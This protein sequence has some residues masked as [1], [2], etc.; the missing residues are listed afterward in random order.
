MIFIICFI[1][2]FALQIE[3]PFICKNFKKMKSTFIIISILAF[4]KAFSQPTLNSSVLPDVGSTASNI[5]VEPNLINTTQTGANTTWNFINIPTNGVQSSAT[6]ISPAGQ[7]GALNFPTANLCLVTQTLINEDI[8]AVYLR[9]DNNGVG[10]VGQ[11]VLQQG[12]ENI[13]NFSSRLELLRTPFTFNSTFNSPITAEITVS[14]TS[15]TRQ[16]QQT[17]VCDGYGTLILPTGTFNDVLRIR[18]TQDYGDF[19]MGT[20]FLSYEVDAYSWVRASTGETLLGKSNLSIDTG[21][22]VNTGLILNTT[23]NINELFNDNSLTMFPQP[24]NDILNFNIINEKNEAIYVSVYDLSGKEVIKNQQVNLAIG[25]STNQIDV[26]SLNAG[27]YLISFT[28][29]SKVSNRIIS[30]Q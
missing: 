25:V 13:T 28:D 3:F 27:L 26:S 10:I 14:T 11:Y 5:A 17:L 12:T 23:N 9:K 24:T 20:E 16:G 2:F 19:F 8:V 21:Q 15:F 29:G 6:Y 4:T 18:T 30:I 7:S 1:Y 22:E